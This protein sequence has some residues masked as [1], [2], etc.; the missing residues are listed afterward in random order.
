[1]LNYKKINADLKKADVVIVDRDNQ[2]VGT[3]YYAIKGINLMMIEEAIA[4]RKAKGLKVD[5]SNRGYAQMFD[6]LDSSRLQPYA[7]SCLTVRTKCQV[8]RKRTPKNYNLFIPHKKGK[9]VF[10]DS[11]YA[12]FI[13]QIPDWK[14]TTTGTGKDTVLFEQQEIRC[15]LCP[16]NLR[17]GD[18]EQ[19]AVVDKL[20]QMF[21]R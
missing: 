14:I 5:E 13:E 7:D 12:D 11:L 2:I 20:R 8:G 18:T 19:D 17:M 1:M 16:V 15:L 6:K 3:Q 10:I 4:Q 21:E 9:L